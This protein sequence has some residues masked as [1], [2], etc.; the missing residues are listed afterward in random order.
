MILKAMTSLFVQCTIKAPTLRNSQPISTCPRG[1][2]GTTMDMTFRGAAKRLDDL[3]LP[4]LGAM[5]GVGED[6]IHAFLDVETTGHG[7]DTQGRPIIL[8]EPHVFLRNLTGAKRAQAVAQGLAYQKWGEK[9]YPRDSYPR[10][11]AACAIDETA[12]LKSAS[13]GLGQ[14]L[15][16]NYAAAGF[17]T[18]QAMVQA[19]MAD[20]EL[21]LLAAVNFIKTNK[22]DDNLRG[23]DWAGFA[24]GYNGSGYRKNAYDTKLANAFRKWSR[25]KDTAWPQPSPSPSA[26]VTTPQPPAAPKPPAAAPVPT[27]AAKPSLWA[28]LLN[29]ILKILGRKPS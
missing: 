17:L 10:L 29:L 16:E 4:K 28:M 20:E 19:M 14:V 7:F 5:I 27:P 8:F 3:D 6:E 24:K 26:P 23:H 2:K 13:W 25:I 11:K 18:V 22:L 15:G 12:A 1:R 9:P 21:Q